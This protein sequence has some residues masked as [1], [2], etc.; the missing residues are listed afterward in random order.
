MATSD[1]DLGTTVT[2]PGLPPLIPS[3]LVNEKSGA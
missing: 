2:E 3:A 1:K